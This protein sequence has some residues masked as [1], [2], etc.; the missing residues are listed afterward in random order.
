MNNHYPI[1]IV[2]SNVEHWDY[3]DYANAVVYSAE[4]YDTGE[5][6][7][8]DELNELP[9]SELAYESNF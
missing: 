4:W 6:L 9:A 8:E 5:S 3:P 1:N 2:L 7:T